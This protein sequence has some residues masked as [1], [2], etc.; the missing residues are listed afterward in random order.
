MDFLRFHGERCAYLLSVCTGVFLLAAAG[1][2]EGRRVTT[3]WEFVD[4]LACEPGLRVEGPER[5]VR[6]GKLWTAAGIC[7][8]LDLA[9]AFIDYFK[10][11]PKPG[12]GVRQ[13]E[14]GKIQMIAQYFP[15]GRCYDPG[16]TMALAPDYIRQAFKDGGR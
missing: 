11:A 12:G 9:L 4:D 15:P 10:G 7:S 5:W 14:A 3:H 6:D 16:E 2:A 13:G 1:L 8:G